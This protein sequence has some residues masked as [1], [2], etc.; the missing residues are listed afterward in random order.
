MHQKRTSI[1]SA[2]QIT[3]LRYPDIA[4]RRLLRALIPE[5]T[6]A[7]VIKKIR[8]GDVLLRQRCLMPVPAVLL[9]VQCCV[10]GVRDARRWLPQ[11][12]STMEMR[13]GG[14]ARISDPMGS[15]SRVEDKNGGSTL[16]AIMQLSRVPSGLP[17]PA[18]CLSGW[19][20]L[21]QQILLYGVAPI[22]EKKS[23]ARSCCVSI[24]GEKRGDGACRP[25]RYQ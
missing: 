21:S 19:E 1:S 9:R 13:E 17:P 15:V 8:V 7:I 22:V 10:S 11:R 24:R 16:W 12:P 20:P 5:K 23:L 4:L 25:G 3:Y 18:L 6:P 2:A 14:L